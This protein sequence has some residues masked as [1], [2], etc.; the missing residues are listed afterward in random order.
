VTKGGFFPSGVAMFAGLVVLFFAGFVALFIFAVWAF[1]A[2]IVAHL[3]LALVDRGEHGLTEEAGC[4]V[5][6]MIAFLISGAA[7][8]V[9]DLV[10]TTYVSLPAMIDAVDRLTVAENARWEPRIRSV[11][12]YYALVLGSTPG[13]WLRFAGHYLVIVLVFAGVMLWLTLKLEPVPD[14][15]AEPVPPLRRNLRLLGL[16][17]V[18]VVTV[19]LTLFPLT[20]WAMIALRNLGRFDI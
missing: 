9:L 6:F 14:H 8:F 13:A 2:A 15:H 5:P 7:A 1:I 19:A 11:G 20:T 16:S 18:A 17:A 3:G 10:F 4:I 12:D